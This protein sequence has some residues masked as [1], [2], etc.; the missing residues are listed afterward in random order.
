LGCSADALFSFD[1][2]AAAS[3]REAP[4]RVRAA[5]WRHSR[6]ETGFQHLTA[7]RDGFGHAAS[8]DGRRSPTTGAVLSVRG[9]YR[10]YSLKFGHGRSE[11]LDLH[12]HLPQINRAMANVGAS[13]TAFRS[14]SL[15]PCRI[16]ADQHSK[17]PSLVI[18]NRMLA[19]LAISCCNSGSRHR[20]DRI[21]HQ[22]AD[23]P[24]PYRIA[25][26][27]SLGS[28]SC[29]LL[30]AFGTVVDMAYPRRGQ[31]RLRRRIL[32]H[33]GSFALAA[34]LLPEGLQAI[35]NRVR[36]RLHFPV[37]R[38]CSD[39]GVRRLVITAPA[40]APAHTNIFPCA[41]IACGRMPKHRA[42]QSGAGSQS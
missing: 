34:R 24:H 40:A 39:F 7:L 27:L 3:S 38:L 20:S 23:P 1:T 26:M 8:V 42:V 2:A 30:P 28:A 9:R 6:Q 16:G 35:P 14:P 25:S 4:A 22:E 41:A 10:G 29:P 32:R 37:A 5:H 15:P 12:Q 31:L 19:S 13:S 18:E 33:A 36:N 21:S 11:I 17:S